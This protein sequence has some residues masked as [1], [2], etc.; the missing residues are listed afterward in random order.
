LPD[1]EVIAYSSHQP[2]YLAIKI[3][4]CCAQSVEPPATEFGDS[5]SSGRMSNYV[6]FGLSFSGLAV[7]QSRNFGRLHI[8]AE[9]PQAC[10]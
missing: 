5:F 2:F 6:A 1:A 4:W 10:Y 3:F 8:V 9:N 7:Q